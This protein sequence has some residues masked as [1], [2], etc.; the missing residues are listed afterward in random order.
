MK[1]AAAQ[2]ERWI[3]QPPNTLSGFLLYGPD[4]G[5]V[6]E[7]AARLVRVMVPDPDDPFNT[8]HLTPEQLKES[9]GLLQEELQAIGFGGG[10]RLITLKGAGNALTKSLKEATDNL[11]PDMAASIALI[12]TAAELDSRSS[13]RALFEKHEHLA[14]LPC[15][16]EEGRQLITTIAAQLQSHGLTAERSIVDYLAE[17]V[18]GDHRLVLQAIDKLALY[19]GEQSS[20]DFAD[21]D[22]VT[23]DATTSTLEAITAAFIHKKLADLSYL[24]GKAHQQGVQPIVIVR[25]LQTTI[26]KLQRALGYILNGDSVDRAIQQLRPPVF[27]KE[28]PVFEHALRCLQN[29]LNRSGNVLPLQKSLHALYEAEKLNKRYSGFL[30]QTMLEHSLLAASARLGR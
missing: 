11:T 23:A 16:I 3:E 7:R 9:P 6:V 5:M 26:R 1:I 4:H 27:F 21:V 17:R 12:V 18:Q 22:A 10:R 24:L 13:L 28:R 25:S 29:T 8:V 14:A 30:P 19:A 2:V 15:Y 20:L